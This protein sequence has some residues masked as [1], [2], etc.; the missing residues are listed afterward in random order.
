MPS[1]PAPMMSTSD[2]EAQQTSLGTALGRVHVLIRGLPLSVREAP[3]DNR[4]AKYFG[5]LKIDPTEGPYHTLDVAWTRTF[6]VE[7]SERLKL[8]MRGKYGIKLVHDGMVWLSTCDG[9][10]ANKGLFLM[11]EKAN[12]LA[13]WLGTV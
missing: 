6:Q 1:P 13:E 3:E 8:I 12:Q 10:S 7:P 5:A 11:A 9:I 4:I 2:T